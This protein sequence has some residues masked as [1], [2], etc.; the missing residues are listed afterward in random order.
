MENETENE[1]KAG[2]TNG[3]TNSMRAGRWPCPCLAQGRHTLTLNKRLL[4]EEKKGKLTQ[5]QGGRR[6]QLARRCPGSSG[7]AARR[8]S[9]QG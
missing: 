1:G 7:P 3:L 8:G 4:N 2:G 6:H 5:E 9:R